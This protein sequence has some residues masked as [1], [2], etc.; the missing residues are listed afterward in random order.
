MQ[1]ITLGLGTPSDIPHFILVGLSTQPDVVASDPT[2]ITVMARQR[3]IT[4]ASRERTISV[5]A[6]TRTVTVPDRS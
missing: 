1:I 2:V 6:R 3:T 4:V 5:A